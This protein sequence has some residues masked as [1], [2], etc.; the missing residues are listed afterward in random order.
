[1][2]AWGMLG[3]YSSA[4]DESCHDK[5]DEKLILISLNA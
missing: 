1:M 4:S 5:A 2:G 3:E